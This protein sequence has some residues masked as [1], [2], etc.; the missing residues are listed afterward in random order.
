LRTAVA[1]MAP[2]RVLLIAARRVSSE[3]HAAD[4]V[5]GGSP[6]TVD[7]W[8]VPGAGHTNALEARQPEWTDRVIRFL[9]SAKCP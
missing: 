6:R 1:A 5:D 8:V 9:D 2:R 3:P 4:H 7:V